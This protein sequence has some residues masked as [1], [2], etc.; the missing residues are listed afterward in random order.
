MAI[1]YP[2]FGGSDWN[3]GIPDYASA[4]SKGLNNY[5]NANKAKYA[6]QNEESL[7]Q[8]NQIAAQ[9]AEPNAQMALKK[10]GIDIQ[11]VLQLM[12]QRQ[13]AIDREKAFQQLLNG[14]GQ[15]SS[16]DGTQ[17][18]AQPANPAQPVSNSPN[19]QD[20]YSPNPQDDNGIG[21]IANVKG[22]QGI[23]DYSDNGMPAEG[24]GVAASGSARDV[25]PG[26][27]PNYKQ[28]L[29]QG[30]GAMPIPQSQQPGLQQNITQGLQANK[31]DEAN[32]TILQPGNPNLAHINEMWDKYPQFR[33]DLEAR[34]FKK[35]QETKFDSKNGITRITTTMP[36]GE[37]RQRVFGNTTEKGGVPLTN[38]VKTYHEMIVG[39]APQAKT[40]I[41]EII[42]APSPVLPPTFLGKLYRPGAR[43]EHTALVSA[44]GETLA[45][46]L[47]FPNTDKGVEL[48]LN[49]VER[50][51]N[52]TDSAYRNRLE[53]LKKSIDVKVEN[54]QKVLDTGISTKQEESNKIVK[55]PSYINNSEQF[56]AWYAMLSPEEKAAVKKKHLGD[57]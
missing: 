39:S 21:N 12:Q 48:A 55:I 37:I 44:T 46:A 16:W 51:D 15:Q 49:L 38:P 43:A 2:S 11:S 23:N 42:K 50:G 33:K 8:Q 1:Q 19:M 34:G 45:K 53:K 30:K 54:S 14:G 26:R 9:Y 24:P 35:T 5:I 22:I 27:R 41:D 6:P 47:G 32:E 20:N 13:T 4:I 56:K 18:S 29:A 3:T 57:K 17:Q 25:F 31:P 40:M 7:A 28:Q 10:G 36:N 52:E